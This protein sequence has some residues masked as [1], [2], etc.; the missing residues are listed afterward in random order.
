MS[1]SREGKQV[2][3]NYLGLHR[4]TGE[5]T[6]SRVAYGGSVKHTVLLDEPIV[7]YGTRRETIILGSSD[8]FVVD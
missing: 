8:T 3:A 1:W 2:S 5:V 7:V 4:I 6:E